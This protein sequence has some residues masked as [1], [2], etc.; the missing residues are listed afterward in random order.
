MNLTERRQSATDAARKLEFRGR[1]NGRR[2][3]QFAASYA[4]TP[5][6]RYG[7][8]FLLLRLRFEG[9]GCGTNWAITIT[10]KTFEARIRELV[11][12]HT[13]LERSAQAML[14][15]RATLKAQYEKLQRLRS[16]LFVKTRSADG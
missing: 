14:S 9:C 10:R 8:V 15:A 4:L 7:N 2:A 3:S 13:T 6:L 1:E 5:C 12:G 16:R 11:T